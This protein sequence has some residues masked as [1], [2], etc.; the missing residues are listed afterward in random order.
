MIKRA[1][2]SIKKTQTAN[3][4]KGKELP[5]KLRSFKCKLFQY[6]VSTPTFLHFDLYLFSCSE[7]T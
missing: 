3:R 7:L 5:W 6:Q 2:M 4:K 1:T